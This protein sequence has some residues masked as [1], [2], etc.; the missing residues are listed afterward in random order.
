MGTQTKSSA[1][2][3]VES[4]RLKHRSDRFVAALSDPALTEMACNL[5]DLRP[6]TDV[7]DLVDAVKANP[8]VT[9]LDLRDNPALADDAPKSGGGGGGALQPLLVALLRSDRDVSPDVVGRLG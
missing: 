5:C 9:C 1:A 8:H 7:A 2:A 3:F 4:L 6:G